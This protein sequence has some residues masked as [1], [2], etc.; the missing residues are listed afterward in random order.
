M[1]PVRNLVF[2]K[3]ESGDAKTVYRVTSEAPLIGGATAATCVT[4]F[5][6]R[7][8]APG[9]QS[10]F[11]YETG[12]YVFVGHCSGPLKPDS[13]LTVASFLPAEVDSANDGDAFVVNGGLGLVP[14]PR[15]ASKSAL[16]VFVTLTVLEGLDPRLTYVVG[17]ARKTWDAPGG[18]PSPVAAVKLSPKIA[19]YDFVPKRGI[20]I[21]GDEPNRSMRVEFMDSGGKAVVKDLG[22]GRFSVDYSYGQAEQDDEEPVPSVLPTPTPKAP[23]YSDN[24]EDPA[25][26]HKKDAERKADKMAAEENSKTGFPA[27]S[28][29]GATST[30]APPAANLTERPAPPVYPTQRTEEKD[31]DNWVAAFKLLLAQKRVGRIPDDRRLRV[32]VLDTGIDLLHDDFEDD[33]RIVEK[34]NFISGDVDDVADRDGHGTHMA[35]ILLGLTQNVDLC[36]AR[37]SDA[38]DRVGLYTAEIAEALRVAREEWEVHIISL[39]LGFE[40]YVPAIHKQI[41][42][43]TNRAGTDAAPRMVAVFAAASNDAANAPRMYPAW[44]D[45]PV[46]GINAATAYGNPWFKNPNA[47]RRRG[48]DNFM[49]TGELV[50]SAQPG[51]GHVYMTGTSVA[52]PVAVSVAALMLGYIDK[53]VPTPQR[54]WAIEPRSPEG[55]RR[56]FNLMAEPRGDYELVNP[57]LFF[58]TFKNQPNKITE[59]IINVLQGL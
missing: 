41:D 16:S 20:I 12:F 48:A 55:V 9:S 5:E 39:S 49:C 57:L 34:R 14:S 22:S 4:W 31:T 8:V 30:P 17:L 51:G 54:G 7:P 18:A 10:L 37:V 45:R 36:V 40:D 52:T 23:P 25:Q 3:N 27:G 53:Y 32:A 42:L 24:A 50:R 29:L 26:A 56:I 35:G 43:C 47:S 33:E 21:R 15:T 58:R 13:R 44:Y 11:I 38:W 6:T 59:D 46:L 19:R 1:A 28:F 2:I